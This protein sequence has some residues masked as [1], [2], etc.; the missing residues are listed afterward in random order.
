MH[1]KHICL[2]CF[3]VRK[4][5]QKVINNFESKGAWFLIQAQPEFRLI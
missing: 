5:P 4:K 2:V 3:F 1:F